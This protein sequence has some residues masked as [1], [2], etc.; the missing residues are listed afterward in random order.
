MEKFIDTL[1]D[2]YDKYPICIKNLKRNKYKNFLYLHNT[3]NIKFLIT[4]TKD[5]KIKGKQLYIVKLRVKDNYCKSLIILY[6][7]NLYEK[8]K[9]YLSSLK[10]DDKFYVIFYEEEYN[11]E[12]EFCTD[13]RDFLIPCFFNKNTIIFLRLVS[14]NNIEQYRN[15]NKNFFILLPI[16][17]KFFQPSERIGLMVDGSCTLSIHNVRYNMDVDLVIFH[18]RFYEPKVKEMLLKENVLREGISDCLTLSEHDVDIYI[19]LLKEESTWIDEKTQ[20]VLQLKA[21]QRKM[22]LDA[23]EQEDFLLGKT[24]NQELKI[25]L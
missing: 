1:K 6:Q 19:Q 20:Q 17:R 10:T 22:A 13:R 25:E 24:K 16:I 5:S 3:N 18:P 2:L 8:E 21:D 14:I 7:N 4:P 11:D 15:L 9:E 23:M 12:F